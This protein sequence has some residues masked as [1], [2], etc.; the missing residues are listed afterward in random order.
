MTGHARLVERKV[1]KSAGARK[2]KSSRTGEKTNKQSRYHGVVS[3]GETPV[4]LAMHKAPMD[5]RSKTT[6][7]KS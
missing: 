4:S 5:V 1:V 7:A 6:L 3:I 2:A